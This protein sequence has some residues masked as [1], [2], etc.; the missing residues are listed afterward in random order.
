V[1]PPAGG[2]LGLRACR[3]HAAQRAGNRQAKARCQISSLVET[4]HTQP[5]PMQRDGHQAVGIGEHVR[6][7]FPHQQRQASRQGPS[8]VVLEGMDD[9]PKLTVVG[10]ERP[11]AG[12]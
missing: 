10:A 9:E 5:P 12:D 11:A 1:V 3:P 7:A 4:A 8:L 6:P 2:Q